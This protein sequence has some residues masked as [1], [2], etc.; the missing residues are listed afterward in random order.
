MTAQMPEKLKYKGKKYDMCSEP[1]RAYFALTGIKFKPRV[2]CSA[3]SRGYVGTW[4]IIDD[5]LYLVKLKNG[6]DKDAES[7]IAEY[8]PDHSD[9]VFAD[10]YSGKIRLPQGKALKYVHAGFSSTYESDL[11]LTIKS[12]IVTKMEVCHNTNPDSSEVDFD[13]NSVCLSDS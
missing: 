1:L 5:R 7:C 2:I 3:L 8:F 6:Y 11:F 10:W 9:R 4:K 13:A 12:G